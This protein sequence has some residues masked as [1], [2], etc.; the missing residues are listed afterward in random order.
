MA[1]VLSGKEAGQHYRALLQTNIHG[2]LARWQQPPV[3]AIII[4]QLDDASRSY[5]RSREKLAK[6]LGIEIRSFVFETMTQDALLNLIHQLN[7][8]DTINGIIIDRPLP[9][10]LQESVIY[11]AIAAHKD[12][13]GCGLIQSGYLM[14]GKEDLPPSTA[15]AVIALLNYYQIDVVGKRVVVLGR[16]KIVGMPVAKMLID[17]HATVTVCHSRT[18]DLKTLCQQ[19]DILVVAIGKKKMI[20]ASY[21]QPQSIVIDVGIHYD[22][23]DGLCGDVDRSL[24]E[25]VQAYSPVPGGV[26]PLTSIMLMSNLLEAAL[27]RK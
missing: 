15:K 2:Y 9:I 1:K 19:A 3:L 13:D 10:S 4:P 14:Q 12:V 27:K 17:R 5:L 11:D 21:V 16:S 8:D 24:Y 26:G 18:K 6:E 7:E 23:Q 25:H 22:A 20:D